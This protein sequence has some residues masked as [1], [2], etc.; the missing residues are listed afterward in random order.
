MSLSFETY[1]PLLLLSVVVY[2]WWVRKRTK[3][4]LTERQVTLL[5]VV[6]S[7]V[8]VLLVLA[9][10]R[11]HFNR[12]SSGISTVFL[13]DVSRSISPE[14]LSAAIRWSDASTILIRKALTRPP[15]GG[16]PLPR[17]ERDSRSYFTA[18]RAAS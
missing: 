12:P 10:M 1:W 9:L 3:T 7:S 8:V 15:G 14:F 2:L 13:I 6:R 5:T 4:F 17:G 16:H 11:P 18:A